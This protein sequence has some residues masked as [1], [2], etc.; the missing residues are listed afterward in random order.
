MTAVVRPAEASGTLALGGDLVVRRLGFGAMQITGPGIWGEP[1]DPDEAVRVLRRA[2]E[3]AFIPWFPLA[4]GRLAEA[5]GE[6]ASIA[7]R[8]AATP[9]QLALARLLQ[10]SPMMLPIPG[11]SKVAHLEENMVA[12]TI[13]LTAEEMAELEGAAG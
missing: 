10:R 3:L 8:K 5:G 1:D 12:A 9:S 11:T 13:R 7:K 6:L 4:T 2:V